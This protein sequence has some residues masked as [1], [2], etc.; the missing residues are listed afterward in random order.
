MYALDFFVFKKVELHKSRIYLRFGD[1]KM[2]Q[3]NILQCITF[4]MMITISMQNLQAM[5][6]YK[7]NETGQTNVKQPVPPVPAFPPAE[8]LNQAEHAAPEVPYPDY[9]APKV[10]Q[11][12]PSLYSKNSSIEETNR[13][14]LSF[15]DVAQKSDDIFFSNGINKE[16]NRLNSD[17]V[18]KVKL[19]WTESL[20]NLF[21]KRSLPSTSTIMASVRKMIANIKKTL[22]IKA[23]NA[24]NKSADDL[25]K[26]TTSS[27]KNSVPTSQ[28]IKDFIQSIINIFVQPTTNVVSESQQN[29]KSST[30]SQSK[31]ATAKS[32]FP[33]WLETETT[34]QKS[35]QSTLQMDQQVSRTAFEPNPWD[36]QN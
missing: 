3:R 18:E 9:A 14:S 30:R 25:A 19:T 26:K 13:N 5:H 23:T 11:E 20:S 35:T 27:W 36:V 34:P 15:D 10:P 21:Q 17:D 24:Q 1:K 2:K 8:F 6:E 22:G 12:R 4:A 7:E 32:N 33:T 31:S 16:T 28:Q 29:Q